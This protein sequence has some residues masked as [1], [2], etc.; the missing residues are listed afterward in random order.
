MSIQPRV[1][2]SIIDDGSAAAAL[3]AAKNGGEIQDPGRQRRK[4]MVERA[5]AEH[6]SGAVN[7]P[8][9][10]AVVVPPRE[11]LESIT[12]R[13]PSGMQ[14]EIGPPFNSTVAVRLMMFFGGRQPSQTEEAI[15]ATI[16]CIREIDGVPV[17]VSDMIGRDR[18]INQIGDNSLIIL[19]HAYR[20]HWPPPAITDLVVIQ[21]KM[22]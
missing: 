1:V 18:I 17:S 4:D 13:L 10:S 12:L 2:S 11:D 19:Q 3:A 5:Q 21:K 14:V 6:R 15:T 22:R 16:L 8:S 9:E 20:E 7:H